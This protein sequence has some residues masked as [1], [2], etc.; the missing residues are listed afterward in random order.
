MTQGVFI[1]TKKK[2]FFF[3][4]S[5]QYCWNQII[6]LR[7]KQQLTRVTKEEKERKIIHCFTNST[8][9]YCHRNKLTEHDDRISMN[10]LTWKII[11]YSIKSKFKNDNACKLPFS[12][13]EQIVILVL[14]RAFVYL[15][16]EEWY[17]SNKK[18]VYNRFN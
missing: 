16:G 11:I 2:S 18:Y 1:S 6:P 3:F 14:K 9:F 5:R 17:V 10:K 12:Q 8:I 13:K 4:P 7:K 15:G